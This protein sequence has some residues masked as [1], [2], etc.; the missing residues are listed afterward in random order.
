[1]ENSNSTSTTS[2][3]IRARV[4]Q[5]LQDRHG[6]VVRGLFKHLVQTHNDYCGCEYCDILRQYVRLKKAEHRMHR[7]IEDDLKV[8]FSYLDKAYRSYDQTKQEA[9]ALKIQKDAIKHAIL[10]RIL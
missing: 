6:E 7:I 3:R 8:Q 1:M 9:K 4:E 2:A 10:Q 5:K